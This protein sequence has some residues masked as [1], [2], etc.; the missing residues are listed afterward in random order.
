MAFRVKICFLDPKSCSIAFRYLEKEDI[1]LANQD[2]QTQNWVRAAG[3]QC[4]FE[5][6][7]ILGALLDVV[8]AVAL[9]SNSLKTL[10]LVAASTYFP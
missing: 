1:I 2:L 7:H 5:W 6:P 3:K 8:V 10:N 9:S 4:E